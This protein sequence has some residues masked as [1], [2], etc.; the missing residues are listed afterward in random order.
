MPKQRRPSHPGRNPAGIFRTRSQT[1]ALDLGALRN[2]TVQQLA[3]LLGVL[4]QIAPGLGSSSRTFSPLAAPA[5]GNSPTASDFNQF[6]SLLS[7]LL[8]V[9]GVLQTAHI[10]NTTATT[11]NTAA[12]IQNSTATAGFGAGGAGGGSGGLL[13]TLLGGFSRGLSIA[14]LGLSL[15]SLFRG[16]QQPRLDLKPFQSPSPLSLEVANT[17]NIL[18]GLPRFDFSADGT[19]RPMDAAA[20]SAATGAATGPSPMQVTVNVSAMDSRSFLDHAPALA[21]AVREAMLHMH[22]INQLVRESF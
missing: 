1:T 18:R 3:G 10:A 19:S 8:R 11:A 12:T 6:A 16:P 7:Q 17:D 22:P 5:A 9:F 14:S 15:F 20:P 13:G 4:A 21:Q 2:N